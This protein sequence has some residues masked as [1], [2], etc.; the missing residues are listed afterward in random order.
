MKSISY[1]YAEMT[2]NEVW[3]KEIPLG[4]TTQIR[5]AAGEV[6]CEAYEKEPYFS[7]LDDAQ[8]AILEM[9]DEKAVIYIA[10]E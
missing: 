10:P 2:V 1:E 9:D 5:N 6:V 7:E 3:M 4:C 8:A